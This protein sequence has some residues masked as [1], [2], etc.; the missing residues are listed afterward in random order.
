MVQCGASAKVH[1]AHP[2]RAATAKPKGRSLI[3]LLARQ[4]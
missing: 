2:H 1:L 3:G 4:F